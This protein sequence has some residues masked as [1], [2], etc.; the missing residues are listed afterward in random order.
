LILKLATFDE[1]TR[2]VDGLSGA[3]SPPG[4]WTLAQAVA[5]CAQSV[6][7]SVTGFPVMRSA[8]FRATAGRLA[9]AS[10]IRRGFLKHDLRAPIP[11][12]PL[13]PVEIT[14]P[15]AVGQLRA[16]V[17]RF[18]AHPGP[19][20]PHF[21]YGNVSPADYEKLHAMHAADHLAA[22]GS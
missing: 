22:F 4:A 18:R 3:V 20:A 2:A 10:F 19:L 17:G 6:E 5:H 13:P 16:A 9:A 8:L 11:G 12:A 15:E 7:L 1:V 21:A 14:L